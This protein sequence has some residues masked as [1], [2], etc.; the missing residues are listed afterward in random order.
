[1]ADD[2]LMQKLHSL[3]LWRYLHH[4]I[5]GRHLFITRQGIHG[6]TSPDIREGDELYTLGD[7]KLPFILRRVNRTA[8]GLYFRMIGGANVSGIMM[9]ELNKVDDL[10][11]RIQELRIV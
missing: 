7:I 3:N 8:K 9:G 6:L 1:M 11:A 4:Y 5:F 2:L 10:M